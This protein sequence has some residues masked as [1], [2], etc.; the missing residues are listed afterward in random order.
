MK[1]VGGPHRI[2]RVVRMIPMIRH[3]SPL[4]QQFAPPAR[5]EAPAPSQSRNGQFVFGF[6]GSMNQEGGYKC[7]SLLLWLLPQCHL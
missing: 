1:I 6:E 5:H 2:D 7:V 4:I 3:A